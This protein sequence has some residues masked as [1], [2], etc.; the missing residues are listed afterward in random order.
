MNKCDLLKHTGSMQQLAYVRPISYSEGRSSNLKAFDVKNNKMSFRV[1]ADKCLDV[2]EFSYAG[3]NFSFLSKPG[4][5]GLAHYDTNGAEAQRSI[6]GGFF[7][8]AGLEN[9]GAPCISNGMDF[10]MHGRIRTTPAE[11]LS[12]DAFWDNDNYIIRISGEMREA[13]LFGENL[14]LRRSIETIFGSN[15]FTLTDEFENQSFRD[16]PLMLLYHINLGFPFLSENTKFYIPTNNISPRNS[17]AQGHESEF[18]IMNPPVD[19]EPEYVFFHDLKH[20]A[21]LNTSVL[22]VNPDLKLA[23]KISWNTK[24]LPHF[25]QWKSIASGDYVVGLE[26]ANS[27]VHGRNYYETNGNIHKINSLSKEKNII[28]FTVLNGDFEINNSISEVLKIETL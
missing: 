3:V 28:I 6:M 27:L 4:L 26:P 7:F 13:M 1:L 10:P 2:S 15:S 17:D 19:N 14:V 21:N 20:D 9:I 11:H 23:L 18:N 24:Y 12:S 22:A 25:I 8:T 5:Q 16:E